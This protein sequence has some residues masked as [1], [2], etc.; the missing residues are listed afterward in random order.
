MPTPIPSQQKPDLDRHNPGNTHW[1][2]DTFA[3]RNNHAGS[4]DYSQSNTAQDL[5]SRENSGSGSS[6]RSNASST[7]ATGSD[8]A[9]SVRGQEGAPGSNWSDNNWFNKVVPPDS[10]LS[11]PK[12]RFAKARSAIF[13]KKGG[14][15]GILGAILLGG[16][17][18]LS[19]FGGPSL[20]LLHI[21]EN[22]TN[23]W[24]SQNTSFER[25]ANKVMFKRIQNTATDGLCSV[26]NVRCRYNRVSNRLL[27]QFEKNN[28]EALDKEGNVVKA[29]DGFDA[30]K[31]TIGEKI[32]N[33]RVTYPNG[34][35]ETISAK[36]F[37]KLYYEKPELRAIMH[38]AYAPRWVAFFDKVFNNGVIKKFSLTKKNKLAGAKSEKEVRESIDK[39]T[40]G[41]EMNGKYEAKENDDEGKEKVTEDTDVGKAAKEAVSEGAEGATK[42]ISK[43]AAANII[44]NGV[45]K[46]GNIVAM[47]A[48]GL[49]MVQDRA[50]SISKTIRLI[51]MT[52]V[53]S[54][55][56]MFFTMADNIKA[57]STDYMAVAVLGTILTTVLVNKSGN[58]TKKAATDGMGLKY[59]LMKEIAP[60]GTSNWTEYVPGGGWARKMSGVANALGSNISALKTSCKLINSTGG[61]L[62]MSVAGGWTSVV[63][64]LVSNL[65]APVISAVFAP[66]LSK[67]IN[68]M[69]G[70]LVSSA[71]VGE[72]AGDALT[73]GAV[74]MFSEAAAAGGNGMLNVDQTIAYERE[75]ARLNLAYAAEQRTEHSP[76]DATSPYTFMGSLYSSF[77]PYMGSFSN[78]S[79]F[80][81]NLVALPKNIVPAFFGNKVSANTETDRM[82]K[83][84]QACDDPNIP[85]DVAAGPFCNISYGA[86]N[87][88]KDPDEVAQSLAGQ[89]NE[90]TGEATGGTLKEWQEK[91][92]KGTDG[93]NGVD[94]DYCKFD[95][96]EKVNAALFTIDQR[97]VDTMDNE[98]IDDGGSNSQGQ[99]S[100]GG[101]LPSGDAKSL[102]QQILDNP[103]ITVADYGWNSGETTPKSQIEN[104]AKGQPAIPD[105]VP[106]QYSRN[107]DPQIL[108]VILLIGQKHK[109]TVSS[110]MR[111][112]MTAGGYSQHP[113]GR[114][115]DLSPIGSCGD[116]AGEE[117]AQAVQELINANALPQGGGIGQST[118]GGARGALNN[119]ITQKGWQSFDDSCNHLHIDLGQGNAAS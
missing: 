7:G 106:T 52:Q 8:Y 44:K 46:T 110:L 102:A 30:K 66:I 28:V 16:G 53:I 113:R 91:C 108:Q 97:V 56:M 85:K 61:Q 15:M 18:M 5:Q 115:V 88:D 114:A 72:D 96:E 39:N 31:S 63:G 48:G 40:K 64:E 45:G 14:P 77:I 62:L 105:S 21:K 10:K 6:S 50:Q 82:K 98:P 29:S 118:C 99:Q 32:E 54:Y 38:R 13:S 74:N 93:E 1:S 19:F 23:H 9:N 83:I 27:K 47:I 24:N 59:G 35:Q 26:V 104:T 109:I 89:Y 43:E 84:W 60:T 94:T 79:S 42:S 90:E 71:T 2:N 101:S 17:S 41:K 49:C 11:E 103:N 36:D 76:F 81:H 111:T 95:S 20:L 37:K 67:L 80:V 4:G 117:C 69:A 65:A 33:L 112:Q 107:V 73:S 86:L 100:Q 22:L 78:L 57:G 75:T 119:A 87:L 92:G 25:R 55:A 34:T 70:T 51:Q 3:G 116:G 58:V 12:S 68:S